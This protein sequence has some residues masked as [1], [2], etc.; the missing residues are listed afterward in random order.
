[1]NVIRW[2]CLLLLAVSGA[3]MAADPKSQ[4]LWLHGRVSIDAEGRVA[5]LAWDQLPPLQAL[6]AGR[7]TAQVKSWDF[8]PAIVDGRP[9]PTQT[10]LMVH[11]RAIEDDSGSVD[12]RFID[13]QTGAMVVN[14]VPPSYPRE[15]VIANV[16]AM[17][18]VEA[19]VAVDGRP[20]VHDLR[21][22]ADS[23]ARYHR[24]L[25][26]EAVET[27]MKV[28]KFHPEVVAGQ[29]IATKLSVPVIFCLEPAWCSARHQEAKALTRT[30][31]SP[32][33]IHLAPHSAVALK[34]RIATPGT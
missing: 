14:L 3:G 11:M 9:M 28:W 17:V 24:K 16:S 29:S 19:S 18:V 1:M 2:V 13:A 20:I 32:S 25:I 27:G 22:R 15:A 10:G 7:I 30:A 8:V 5:D 6:V 23:G 21:Y 26:V 12:L 31:S 33:T 4:E 34:T